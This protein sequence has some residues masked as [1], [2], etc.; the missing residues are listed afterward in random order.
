MDN[1]AKKNFD[2]KFRELDARTRTANLTF[3][4][5]YMINQPIATSANLINQQNK[6]TND[7]MKQMIN[8]N[9]QLKPINVYNN[10]SM[11]NQ[12][13][14]PTNHVQFDN[15][16][17]QR[18]FAAAGQ[19]LTTNINN[20]EFN[21]NVSKNS[22]LTTVNQN[23]IAYNYQNNMN[24]CQRAS[25]INSITNANG[26]VNKQYD[27]RHLVAFQLDN[28]LTGQQKVNQNISS[29]AANNNHANFQLNN[30]IGCN[31][32]F[33]Q[34]ANFCSQL[35]NHTI[36]TQ[37]QISSDNSSL[38]AP[39]DQINNNQINNSNQSSNASDLANSDSLNQSLVNCQ[40]YFNQ[41]AA[42]NGQEL[43]QSFIQLALQN[44]T[45]QSDNLPNQMNVS[46]SLY[47]F[48]NQI[49]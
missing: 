26:I 6:K 1:L 17:N 33:S 23:S 44:A 8:S 38:N 19:Q 37:Q 36:N 34:N 28:P 24:N 43:N 18:F 25:S 46:I 20:L 15:L 49:N 29:N 10:Q 21:A 2:L 30:Q 48:E 12:L 39:I 11:T 45:Y 27:Q 14:A 40:L 7:Q 3:K 35:G 41:Q 5:N 13:N 31:S 4:S 22:K 16:A 47:H 32:T 42:N 9:S